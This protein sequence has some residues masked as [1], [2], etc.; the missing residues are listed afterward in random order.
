MSKSVQDHRYSSIFI[1][2]RN[3]MGLKKRKKE[4][5]SPAV[6]LGKKKNKTLIGCSVLASDWILDV[7]S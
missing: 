7:C 1:D 6:F 5:I 4:V 2:I 3:G